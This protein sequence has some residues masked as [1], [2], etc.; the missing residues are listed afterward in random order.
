MERNVTEKSRIRYLIG[1]EINS[2][3]VQPLGANRLARE[4]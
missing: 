2:D 4:E 1:T 3:Y